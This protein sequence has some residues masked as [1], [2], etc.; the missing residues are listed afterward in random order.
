MVRYLSITLISEISVISG[1]LLLFLSAKSAKS[2]DCCCCFYL[3][4][5]RNLRTAVA[6]SICEICRVPCFRAVAV[7]GS[8][9]SSAVLDSHSSRH[10][11]TKPRKLPGHASAHTGR[12]TTET[13]KHGTQFRGRKHATRQ[14]TPDHRAGAA[15]PRRPCGRLP[16]PRAKAY[17]RGR[18]SH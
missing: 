9:F 2:A 13:R 14:L 3:R 6:V 5:L 18:P 16:L 15:I 8:M 17:C 7:C 1:L 12:Q 10:R 4:N 11:R